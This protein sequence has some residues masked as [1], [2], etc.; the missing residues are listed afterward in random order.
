MISFFSQD[1][2]FKL[3]K[4]R[5]YK[6]WFS[7]TAR[8]KGQKIASLAVVFCSDSYILALN[9]RFLG[10]DYCTD[11]IAFDARLPHE[12]QIKGASDGIE[13]DIFIS[14]DTVRANAAF[15]GVPFAK[16]LGRVMI[17]GLLHL[18]GY[19][20]ITPKEKA[21]MTKEEDKALL[22]LATIA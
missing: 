1:I 16:E 3:N 13:G 8:Q 14:I 19:G 4:R 9:R 12:R 7:E 18:L 6:K 17:H 10:H 21:L 2:D 11:V 15:Y 22:F 20:D 5:S